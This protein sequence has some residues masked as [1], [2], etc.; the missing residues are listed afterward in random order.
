MGSEGRGGLQLSPL[1]AQSPLKQGRWGASKQIGGGVGEPIACSRTWV[2]AACA[3]LRAVYGDPPDPHLYRG[4]SGLARFND[5]TVRAAITITLINEGRGVGGRKSLGVPHTAPS[6]PRSCTPSPPFLRL[7]PGSPSITQ[8]L[9]VPI[10]R[11]L[12]PKPAI[13]PGPSAPPPKATHYQA[14]ERCAP[15]LPCGPV[16]MA[17]G[18]A[19][20]PLLQ[21]AGR[22]VRA[23]C[24]RCTAG[25]MLCRCPGHAGTSPG[26]SAM[27]V[28]GARGEV[29]ASGSGLGLGESPGLGVRTGPQEEPRPRGQN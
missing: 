26:T 4:R 13:S 23:A 6:L 8:R 14:T 11:I 10:A 9:S 24:G 27:G 20:W 17:E 21:A 5:R 28:C 29:W 18:W 15:S 7:P 3:P 19:L 1:H 25:W 16:A 12:P 22:P 2:S